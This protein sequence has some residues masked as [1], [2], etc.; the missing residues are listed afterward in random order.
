MRLIIHV[1]EA[2]PYDLGDSWR[3]TIAA[4]IEAEADIVASDAGS[5]LLESPAEHHRSQLRERVV[6]EATARLRKAG[7]EY[8][9][10]GGVR[11]SLEDDTEEA[12]A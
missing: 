6:R 8:M 7:D 11:W 4:A 2:E 3:Y 10:P 12:A 1:P 9:D 5:D